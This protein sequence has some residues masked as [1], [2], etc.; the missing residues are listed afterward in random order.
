MVE[1]CMYQ[2]VTKAYDHDVYKVSTIF[3][4]KCNECYSSILFMF[5]EGIVSGHEQPS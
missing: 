1:M 2:H 5:S 3:E 4:G